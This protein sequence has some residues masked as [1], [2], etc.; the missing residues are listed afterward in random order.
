MHLSV[1]L[2]NN[3]S[4]Q[5]YQAQV[6]K[7]HNKQLSVVGDYSE[8]LNEMPKTIFEETHLR[9]LM[10][11]SINRRIYR[12]TLGI[13]CDSSLDL[14]VIGVTKYAKDDTVLFTLQDSL[15]LVLNYLCDVDM[16]VLRTLPNYQQI[17]R[18]ILN[19]DHT[20]LDGIP[21]GDLLGLDSRLDAYLIR[22]N[23]TSISYEDFLNKFFIEVTSACNTLLHQYVMQYRSYYNDLGLRLPLRSKNISSVVFGSEIEIDDKM[24]LVPGY[25]IHIKSYKRCEYINHINEIRSEYN[26]KEVE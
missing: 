26:G 23:T 4:D 6:A 21:F 3:L 9:N 2:Y 22:I 15:D 14:E 10:S 24:E 11:A 12:D 5:M 13:M 1:D 25:F 20:M 17:S 18:G 19:A 16:N 8:Y 7:L